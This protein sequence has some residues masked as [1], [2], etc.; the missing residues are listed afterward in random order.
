MGDKAGKLLAYRARAEAASR[1]IPRIRLDSDEVTSDP[2]AINNAFTDYYSDLYS[3]EISPLDWEGPNPLDLLTYPQIDLTVA[4]NLGAPI[5]LSE[6]KEAIKALQSNKSP[7]PD[8][9]TTEFFKTYSAALA[10]ILVRVF[11]DARGKGLLPPTM[12]EASITLL[13][14]KDKDPLLCN[15]Y[16]PIS[17]LNVDFKILAKVLASRL[18]SIMPT[19]INS[20][21]TGFISGRH[22]SSNTRKLFN[23]LYSSPTDSPELILSL[24]AEKAFDRVEWEYLFYVL[25]K[26]GLSSGFVEWIKLLY[27]SP[28]AS[29]NTNG[30]KSSLFNLHRGTRQGCP[31]S[32]LLFALAVEPLAIWLRSENRFEGI[33]RHGQLHKLSFYA[34][35]LLLYIS[36]PASSIPI[37]LDI[38]KKFGKYS[39]YKLNLTKSDYIPVNPAADY[40]PQSSLP[41]RKA[42]N[43]FKYLGVHVTKS[44]TELFSKNF[45]SLLDRC[46]SD[47]TR[48]SSLPLSLIGR[49]NLIKMS[50]LPQY[51]YL[52]QHLPIYKVLFFQTRPAD[53][54]FSLG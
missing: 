1:L 34:D 5:T 13:L 22:S 36:N 19:L 8:G 12:S 9:Y 21:Q 40:L 47:L 7:G 52:F 11:N 50:L 51:L 32:P 15:S 17:L 48:W 29:V 16:R 39:G 46:K 44:F 37:I 41:F 42:T 45:N 26:F 30:I 53:K 10:P 38:F 54:L 33:T 14:K 2:A 49:I 43:G 4:A 20:D 28:V 27:A 23:I 25:N 24:D 6:V 31:L 3:S 18:Q 35:D